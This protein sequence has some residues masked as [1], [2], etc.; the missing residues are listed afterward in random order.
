MF[1]GTFIALVCA[2]VRDHIQNFYRLPTANVG[3]P[4]PLAQVFAKFYKVRRIVS[5]KNRSLANYFHLKKSEDFLI[6][7]WCKVGKIGPR[8]HI[9]APS[10]VLFS[11]V[12]VCCPV[13]LNIH[14]FDPSSGN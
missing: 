6:Y 5:L 11:Y 1:L 9:P 7:L 4:F 2:Q 10:K 14:N 3:M 13:A 8:D 12:L